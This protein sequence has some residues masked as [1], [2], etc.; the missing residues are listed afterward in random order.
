MFKTTLKMIL[1]AKRLYSEKVTESF[2][3]ISKGLLNSDNFHP[4]AI[5]IC[6]D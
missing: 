1:P 4:S 2:C 6:R 3:S 5:I